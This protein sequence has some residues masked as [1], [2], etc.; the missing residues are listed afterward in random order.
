MNLIA[1]QSVLSDAMRRVSRQIPARSQFSQLSSLVRI[2]AEDDVL[3]LLT[4][5]LDSATKCSI[6]VQVS[7]N[8]AC[9][10]SSRLLADIVSAMPPGAVE[11]SLEDGI[12]FIREKNMQFELRTMDI[13]EFPPIVFPTGDSIKL[14]KAAFVNL[15]RQILKASSKDDTR[16]ILTSIH[17]KILP[18]TLQ[19]TSTDSYRLSFARLSGIDTSLIPESE[20]LIPSKV[21]TD[22][23]RLVGS[24]GT[25][26][27]DTDM[28]LINVSDTDINFIFDNT[29]VYSRLV[30][31]KFPSFESVTNRIYK[32][33]ITVSKSNLMESLK[34]ISILAKD[35]ISKVNISFSDIGIELFI[36]SATLGKA[37]EQVEAE[38]E[39]DESFSIGFNPNFLM[40]GIE[41]LNGN[42]IEISFS[43]SKYAALI[44]SPEDDGFQYYLMPIRIKD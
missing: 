19:F 33:K 14:P 32:N 26:S 7:D 3:N 29:E 28:I 34:R 6:Q 10:V 17:M 44:S 22:V 4:T 13:D 5:D 23:A 21:I 37:H 38:Y 2:T 24:S 1:E 18:D 30:N 9:I 27:K 20:I 35:N 15:S 40:D 36:N 25:D 42:T 12:L 31:G 41:V 16:P 8:G 43:D 11:M 39:G